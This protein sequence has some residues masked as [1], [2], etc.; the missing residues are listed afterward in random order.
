MRHKKLSFQNG[1][2]F[3]SYI[4]GPTSTRAE[5][6]LGDRIMGSGTQMLGGLALEAG[7]WTSPCLGRPHILRNAQIVC[8]RITT[9]SF[10]MWS[11]AHP[12]WKLMLLQKCFNS[13]SIQNHCS[14]YTESEI[15]E[16]NISVHTCMF[17][18]I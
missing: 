13:C 2:L 3:S 14:K 1:I 17:V 8:L 15:T 18:C 5:P 6:S 9:Q 16:D 11:A 12:A 7:G 4:E 10:R